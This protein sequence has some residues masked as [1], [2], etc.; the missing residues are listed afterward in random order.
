MIAIVGGGITGL[1]LGHYLA[2]RGV[3]FTVLEA[4]SRPGGVI[5]SERVDSHLVEWGPQRTRL[6][7]RVRD[8]VEELGLG[9][10]LITAPDGLPLL[11]YCE[12]KL[13][14]VPFSIGDFVATDMFTGAEKLRVLAEPFT[15]G[16]RPGERVAGF[17]TR[18]FG[19]AAYE[20]L[21]GP[22]YGGLYASDPAD[23][24]V[25]QSLGHVL[26]EFG[27]GRSLLARLLRRGGRISPPAACS[28]QDGL[29]TLTTALY[30]KHH[31]NVRLEAPVTGLSQ[32]GGGWVVETAGDSLEASAVVL[33]APADT[34]SALLQT[35]APDAAARIGQLHYNPLAVVHLYAETD[36]VGLGY[37]VSFAEDLVTRGVTW[38]DSLFG[39]AGVYTA[40][41]GG[42]RSPTTV[43]LPDLDVAEIAV[44]EFARVTGYEAE[45][46][47][48]VRERM[49]AWDHTW[50]A[51]DGLEL[52][53][54]IHLA[55]NW[56]AR[57]GIP[58]RL[59]QAF[60]LSDKVTR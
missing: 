6:V 14:R 20:N 53:A 1:A 40:Y 42:A 27:I 9:S 5:R 25:D 59:G 28:F 48:V 26:R 49:P 11:V 2:D 17:F 34:T 12:G 56:Q 51:L 19:R 29:Q 58:G 39:R 22:L 44:R 46:I 23:M 32:R 31:D 57:P 13:R 37:Q 3:E 60:M 41:L 50:G 4:T 33:T 52:P 30:K 15:G 24:V 8:L 36:L 47:S 38:N 55:A 7:G 10:D 54:G 45:P 43:D 16:A 35:V 21:L 18:K